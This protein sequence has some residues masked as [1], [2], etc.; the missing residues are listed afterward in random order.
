VEVGDSRVSEKIR[1]TK[2]VLEDM[3]TL[4]NTFGVVDYDSARG[5]YG[6]CDTD[7]RMWFLAKHWE[8]LERIGKLEKILGVE[9]GD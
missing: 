9:H 6:E 1:Q 7:E 2:Q 4:L 5:K 3:F 8:L